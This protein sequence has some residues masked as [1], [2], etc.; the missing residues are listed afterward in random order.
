MARQLHALRSEVA[1][2][3]ADYDSQSGSRTKRASIV[4]I[5]GAIHVPGVRNHLVNGPS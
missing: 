2:G 5:V 1:A 4:A 3:A